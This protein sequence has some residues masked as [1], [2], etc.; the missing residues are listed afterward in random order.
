[1][2]LNPSKCAFGVSS[3]KFLGFMVNHRGIEANP[4]KIQALLDMQPPQKIKEVQKLTGKIVALNRFI[5][6]ETDCCKPFFQ[7]LRKGKDF[8]WTAD[9]EQSFQDLKSYLGKPHLLSNPMKELLSFYT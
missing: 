3:G 1:M 4:A 5:S 2:K 8:V 6:R 7:A 9:Y